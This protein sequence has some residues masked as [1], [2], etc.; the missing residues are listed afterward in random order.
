MSKRKTAMPEPT[1]AP[2]DPNPG[3]IT[4][5]Q[6]ELMRIRTLD[7]IATKIASGGV[8][9]ARES[10]MLAA[11]VVNQTTANMKLRLSAE[12]MMPLF[13]RAKVHPRTAARILDLAGVLSVKGEGYPV[14]ESAD[15]LIAHFREASEKALNERERDIDRTRKAEADIAEK[16][17]AKMGGELCQ[18]KQ[19]LDDFRDFKARVVFTI[20]G[21]KDL[22]VEMQATLVADIAA[23]ELPDLEDA[24]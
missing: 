12:K 16:N 11:A 10:S 9:T 20:Q 15:A 19:C 23:I 22:P 18:K 7:N 1:P 14:I 6:A 2:V 8:P 24:V 21:R 3:Q 13:P 4:E 17:A 5:E